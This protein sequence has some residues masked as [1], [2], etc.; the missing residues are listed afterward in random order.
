MTN[1]VIS[2]LGA[3]VVTFAAS[4]LFDGGKFNMVHIQNATLAGG[5]AVGS[6]ANL[7]ILPGGKAMQPCWDCARVRATGINMACAV[8]TRGR[9]CQEVR[10]QTLRV[11]GANLKISTHTIECVASCVDRV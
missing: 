4:A 10:S 7:K 3:V 5:V 1:T 2:L 6:S 11:Q 8:S 9:Y